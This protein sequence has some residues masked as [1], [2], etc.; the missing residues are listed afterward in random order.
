MDRE[1]IALLVLGLVL[2]FVLWSKFMNSTSGYSVPRFPT[3]MSPDEAQA[4]YDKAIKE[5]TEDLDSKV[6]TAQE[7]GDAKT[8]IKLTTEGQK[9]V[10]DL[11]AAFSTYSVSKK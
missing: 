9:A 7:A 3:S 2:L 11:N 10:S 1:R 6:K 5:I 4:V 8:V